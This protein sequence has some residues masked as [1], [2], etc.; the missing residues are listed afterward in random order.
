M[1]ISTQEKSRQMGQIE[2]WVMLSIW[3]SARIFQLQKFESSIKPFI[4]VA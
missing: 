3:V 4:K 2:N 1:T